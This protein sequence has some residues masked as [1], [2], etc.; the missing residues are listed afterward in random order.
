M[1]FKNF[2]K[3]KKKIN[4]DIVFC[5]EDFLLIRIRL[6]CKITNFGANNFYCNLVA[7]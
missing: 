4:R 2:S 7:T 3:L 5:D 6:I 1:N